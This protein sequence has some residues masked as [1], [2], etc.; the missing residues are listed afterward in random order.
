[1]RGSCAW[2]SRSVSVARHRRAQLVRIARGPA[3]APLRWGY[4]A[5]S[6]LEIAGATALAR[7]R[8]R[9]SRTVDDLTVIAKTFE[10]PANAR[11]T[12]STL[13][14]VFDGAVVIA[15]DSRSPQSF[16]DAGISTYTITATRAGFLTAAY[17]QRQPSD[18]AMPIQMQAGEQ[19]DSVELRC[20]VRA[21]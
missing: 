1:M 2:P 18:S 3:G 11:R 13:R 4:A 20:L 17:G 7:L 5:V 9:P 19:R 21:P 8:G 6:E 10:R 15:D 16:D 12:V 14:R